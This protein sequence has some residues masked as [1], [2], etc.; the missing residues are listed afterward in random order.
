MIDFQK[1]IVL[2]SDRVRLEPLRQDHFD[3]L[4]EAGDQDELL[5]KYSFNQVHTKELLKAYLDKFIGERKAELRYAFAIYDNQ[6]QRYAGVTTFMNISNDHKRLEIGSTWLGRKFQRT[7]LNRSCKFL[8]L[9][10]C[11]EEVGM[12]RVEFKTDARNQQSKTAILKIGA[13]FEGEL[14]SHSVMPDGYR[15]NTCVYSIIQSEWPTI[16]TSIFTGL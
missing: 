8:L 14:R 13:K 2:I 16:K 11:F 7:G 10:Y 15:R 5:L 9:R 12:E 1:D 3:G 6:E 4:N